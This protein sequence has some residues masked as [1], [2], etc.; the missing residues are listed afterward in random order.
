MNTL[1]D[2]V[3]SLGYPLRKQGR[4][5]GGGKCPCCGQSDDAQSNKLCV[6][7]GTDG[8]WRW[9]CH[10]CSARGDAADFLA[11]SQGISLREAI[12]EVKSLMTSTPE[13][14]PAE[15]PSAQARRQAIKAAL[16]RIAQHAHF[17]SAV[18]AYLAGRGIQRKTLESAMERGL[19]ATLPAEPY[20][21]QR[22]LDEVVGAPLLRQAGFL[23]PGARWSALAFRPLLGILPGQCGVEARLGR[24]PLNGEVKAIRFG[25]LQW[26]WWW[27]AQ[28]TLREVI[29]TEGL[30]DLL[31]L[32]QGGLEPH[33]A[34]MA[35][36]GASSWRAGWFEAVAMKHGRQVEFAVGLDADD[37]GNRA[38]ESLVHVIRQQGLTAHR[39]TPPAKDWNCALL[40][41]KL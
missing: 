6:Y 31:S 10:A 5:W 9:R 29:I 25:Q 19:V 7:I 34:I 32:V 35:L 26:P 39:V 3:R 20:A 21:A 18:W 28:S 37:A 38:A 23:K 27:P 15:A 13:E 17:E 8:K 4:T 30:I 12:K 22:F 24:A 40:E 14:V 41:G 2:L 36:P 16:S 1:P 33:Q 11:K